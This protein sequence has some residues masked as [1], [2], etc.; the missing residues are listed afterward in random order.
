[1]PIRFPQRLL[2]ALLLLAA[3]L[4]PAAGA[5][6]APERGFPLIQSY[7]PS[8]P[9]A[10]PQYFGIA[11]DSRGVLYAA[12]LGGLLIYDGAWWQRVPIGRRLAAFSVASDAR[13]RIAAGGYGDLG[14][15]EPDARGTL[16]FV[17][18]LDRLP[19]ADRG[20]DQILRVVPAG[21]GFAFITDRWLYVWDGSRMTRTATFP[22]GRPLPLVFPVGGAVYAWSRPGI[23][24]L[25]GAR[26]Q[27]VPG[28]EIFRDRRVDEILPAGDRGLLVSVRDEGF[29]L[30]KNGQAVPFAPE[31]SV[32]AREKR[33][34]SGCPLPDGR[35]ALG[36]VLGGLL[37]LRPDG[38]VDQVID[39]QRG[40]PDDFVGG[41]VLDLEGALWLSLNNGLVRVE[42]SSPTSVIDGRMGLRGSI[43]VLGSYQ[44][45]LLVGTATGL[46]EA[47]GSPPGLRL[48]PGLPPA[49]WSL[50]STGDRLLVGTAFGVY[51]A[52]P[53]APR[54]ISTA[55]SETVYALAR[56]ASDPDLV[57]AGLGGGLAILRRRGGEWRWEGKIPGVSAE[58]R[59]FAEG[60][61]S[62]WCGT[63]DG[64]LEIGLPLGAGAPR[65]RTLPPREETNV[66]RAAG[67]ILAVTAEHSYRIDE[68]RGT[69][70]N[71]PLLA[72][73]GKFTALAEDP[74]GN[75]WINT[76]PLSVAV[77][78]RRAWKPRALPE[79]PA[80]SVES[81]LAE[82][83]GTIWL[84]G[85]S[86][87][88]RLGGPLQERT[89]SLPAAPLLGRL[90]EGSRLLFGGAP[91]ASPGVA[92]LPY[93]GR[94]LRIE[95]AP[96]SFRAGLHYQTRLEPLD[97]GWSAPTAEPFA[98][99]ARVPPGEYT[100]HVR[101]LGP[102]GVPGRETSWPFRVKP[103]WFQ[104]AWAM[105]LWL[106]LALLAVRGWAEIRERTLR[107]RAARLESRVQE[108]TVEL[109]AKIEEL[110]R[111]HSDLAAANA[112]LEEISQRDELT[113]IANRR[114][115]QQALD[116]EWSHTRQAIA[117][118][119]ID[120]D[121]FK[122][123]NDTQGHL[124]GD[125]CL[126]AVAG[127]VDREARRQGGL[128]ARYGG[129]ELAVLLPG[130]SLPTALEIAERLRQGIESLAIPHPSAPL[131]KVTA[132]LG[133]ATLDPNPGGNAEDLIE[134]A[135]MAL[136]R[137]KAEGKNRVAAG[138]VRGKGASENPAA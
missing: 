23:S 8:L 104:S 109:R 86:Q 10:E 81:I 79:I 31:A 71:E 24:R 137:A 42:V 59:T 91:G 90:T 53:G 36:S 134:A 15:I 85:E 111:A 100:F 126:Q 69:L 21:P 56:S 47:A 82:P 92:E 132:S 76:R 39:S 80:R 50:L 60:R 30:F 96:L 38:T 7:Q 114:R 138:G 121:F 67:R 97:T 25:V 83:D 72:G 49:V 78:E 41:V 87:V 55:D 106:A 45:H 27:P 98:E 35:W 12:N 95:F 120:L 62:L 135:D 29:F 44:G 17:S 33:I 99:L 2:G 110:G 6:L 22:G 118:I 75:L 48:V 19:P 128:A 117:F 5:V 61:G 26:L 131:G 63:S 1:M 73:R 68:D 32:W 54:L 122:L 20:F 11:R 3:L 65:I 74:A 102:G 125:L 58:V 34:I 70:V 108:Q 133:V 28:G 16:R 37:L 107:Q 64:V 88:F 129:E 136:Y 119:L 93:N 103:P 115:L 51:E 9:E 89:A 52:G 43:Y 84:G 46:F 116:D 94:R 66:F 130:V 113:G 112:R 4:A 124:A 14:L 18:L 57:W 77:R 123:L 101:T 40:L 13:G 127:L 105:A